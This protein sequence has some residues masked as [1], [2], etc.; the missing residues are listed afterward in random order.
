MFSLRS[1]A[2][3]AGPL[4]VGLVG[5][6]VGSLGTAEGAAAATAA[7]VWDDFNGDG[8]AD[9]A[10]AADHAT[11]GGKSKAGYLTSSPS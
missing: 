1:R 7:P 11:V 8:Y 9:L 10:I 4:A 6:G 5:L 3:W 2:R